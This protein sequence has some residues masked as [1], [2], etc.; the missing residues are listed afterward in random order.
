MNKEAI[1]GKYDGVQYKSGSFDF[2]YSEGD[3]KKA[4][5]EY[6]KQ[7]AIDF[8]KWLRENTTQFRNFDR[9]EYFY[10][11][12]KVDYSIEDI[13]AEFLKQYNQ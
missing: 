13:Y 9:L 8:G 3:A 4:M 1:I 11:L 2:F 12:N 5:D 6:A 10:H 7:V